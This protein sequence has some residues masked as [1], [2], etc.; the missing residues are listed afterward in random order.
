MCGCKSKIGM[1]RKGKNINLGMEDIIAGVVG[2]VAC[3]ALNLPLNKALD[4][5]PQ[6]T[7]DTVGKVLPFAKIGAGGYVAMNKKMDRRLRMAGAG[8]AAAGGIEAAAKFAPNLVSIS[9]TGDVFDMLG[10]ADM[11][12]L[13]IAPAAPLESSSFSDRAIMGTDVYADQRLAL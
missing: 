2:G 6:S 13:P 12:A 3:F 7:Q 5:Q 4:S 10:S 11:L 9:G 1:A 8:F